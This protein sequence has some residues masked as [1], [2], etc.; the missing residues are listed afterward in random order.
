MQ[1]VTHAEPIPVVL[2]YLERLSLRKDKIPFV[3]AFI[4]LMF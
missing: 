2:F 4:L 3:A 1:L